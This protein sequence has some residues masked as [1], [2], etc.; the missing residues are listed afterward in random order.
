METGNFLRVFCGRRITTC[1]RR[2]RSTQNTSNLHYGLEKKWTYYNQEAVDREASK[3]LR[4]LTPT[5]LMFAGRSD[6][7]SHLL[8]CSRFRC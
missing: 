5:Q 3:H 1:L 7:G 6:D 8:V 2:Y 4:L